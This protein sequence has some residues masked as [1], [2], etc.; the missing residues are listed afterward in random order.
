MPV[1]AP[2]DDADLRSRRLFH[3]HTPLEW[4]HR[5]ECLRLLASNE[6]GRI[7]VVEGG[8]P[9]IFPVNYALDGENIL[10]RTDD[11]AKLQRGP[12]RTACFE[13]DEIDRATHTGWSV[14]VVGRLDEVTPMDGPDYTRAMDLAAESWAGG[15]KDHLLRLV[16]SRITGRRIPRRDAGTRP[17]EG[18]PHS[19]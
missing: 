18:P 2:M 13:V 19:G 16:S 1:P 9:L 15:P 12:G 6:V 17:A 8:G 11:G 14:V 4:I 3:L 7:V 10:F 5:E